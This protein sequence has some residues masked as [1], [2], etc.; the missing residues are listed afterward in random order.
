MTE[1]VGTP[2]LIRRVAGDTTGTSGVS[3][4]TCKYEGMQAWQIEVEGS[5]EHGR[6]EAGNVEE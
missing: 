2:G 5:L 1:F 3:P 4:T 6:D